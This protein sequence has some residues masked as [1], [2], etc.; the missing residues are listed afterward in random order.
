[1]ATIPLIFRIAAL[2]N[3]IG[4]RIRVC[5]DEKKEQANQSVTCQPTLMEIC[6]TTP[7]FLKQNATCQRTAEGH[8]IQIVVRGQSHPIVPRWK[9][10]RFSRARNRQVKR[11]AMLS[12]AKIQDYRKCREELYGKLVSDD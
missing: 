10:G 11:S 4:N 3:K 9:K 8:S 12:I 2:Q 5:I 6:E 7:A 1:M